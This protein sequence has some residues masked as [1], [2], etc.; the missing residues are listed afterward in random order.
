MCGAYFF[1]FCGRN[2]V[3]FVIAYNFNGKYAPEAG[4][5][6]LRTA[7]FT[8]VAPGSIPGSGVMCGLTVCCWFSILLREVFL[9]VFRYSPLFNN[10]HF[11]IPIRSWNARTFLKEFLGAPWVNKLH[12]F[13]RWPEMQV[14]EMHA[15]CY[16]RHKV[17]SFLKRHQDT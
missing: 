11:Q 13:F 10:Q 8:R 1:E 4:K 2:L 17:S 14:N 12:F 9:R 16:K 5:T 6:R 3:C 15:L 7:F